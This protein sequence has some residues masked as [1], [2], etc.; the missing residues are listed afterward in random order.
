MK[1]I[2]VIIPAAGE[3]KRMRPLSDN[4]SKALIPV[5][6]KPIISWIFDELKEIPNIASIT[7]VQKRHDI[8]NFISITYECT[9][10]GSKVRYVDQDFRYNGPGGA[11]ISGL[12][13]I[14]YN[15]EDG[16][17]IWLGDTIC[18]Y[19]DFDFST[20]FLGTSQTPAIES[21]R[22]CIAEFNKH[23]YLNILHDKK[24]IHYPEILDALIGIYYVDSI[25]DFNEFIPNIKESP[26]T[27]IQISELLF[28]YGYDRFK[29]LDLTKFWYDC[30]ELET[31]YQSKARL[32]NFAAREQTKL[33][34]DLE[35][36]TVTKSSLT[37]H[38]RKKLKN[39]YDW[40]KSCTGTRQIYVP[41]IIDYSSN[42]FEYSYTMS[43]ESGTTLS[44]MFCYENIDVDTWFSLIRKVLRIYHSNFVVNPYYKNADKIFTELEKNFYIRK[45]IDRFIE[46]QD[47]YKKYLT[48]DDDN[49]IH[50]FFEKLKDNMPNKSNH[51]VNSMVDDNLIHGDFHFGNIL[52][53]SILNKYTFLDPRG[54]DFWNLFTDSNY[55]MAKLYHDIY[56]GYMLIVQNL[57]KIENNEVVFSDKHM[58]LLKELEASIDP[59]LESY[60]YNPKYIK[61]LAISLVF[62]CVPF[63]LDDPD[64]CKAFILRSVQLMKEYI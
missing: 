4:L 37:E 32:I 51:L 9:E 58:K 19:N 12:K 49:V 48:Q 62:S 17:L 18:K 27:E 64:H 5:N 26:E 41:K 34:V 42:S 2:H 60:E 53:D 21:K 36:Q 43:Y 46:Y 45:C 6:G 30:G 24:K 14:G 10:I 57:Y 47:T 16:L 23:Q 35:R 33:D 15:A 39:E 63:H 50:A 7:I 31:Y 28:K 11:I 13:E 40:F 56:C 38:N 25:V 54:G 8:E 3:A 29:K 61:M 52:Y 55:D 59:I 20:S 22:W 44:D 1:R